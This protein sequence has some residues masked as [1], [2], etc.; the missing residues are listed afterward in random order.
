MVDTKRRHMMRRGAQSP[1]PCG[2]GLRKGRPWWLATKSGPASHV[3][4]LYTP[5][6]GGTPDEPRCTPCSLASKSTSHYEFSAL[7]EMVLNLKDFRGEPIQLS[8]ARLLTSSPSCSRVSRRTV[9]T[10]MTP[11][12]HPIKC[13]SDAQCRPNQ[14]P[15]HRRGSYLCVIRSASNQ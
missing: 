3:S 1:D 12:G 8:N 7:P 2:L 5:S 15:V 9:L 11:P 13:A 10:C 14:T 4:W 6:Y